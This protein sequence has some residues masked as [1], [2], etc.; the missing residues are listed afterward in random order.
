[1]LVWDAHEVKLWDFVKTP[2]QWS[3]QDTLELRVNE[4][5]AL[6]RRNGKAWWAV[7]LRPT[8]LF[9]GPKP[10]NPADVPTLRAAR[11]AIYHRQV[12]PDLRT[13][14][15]GD[16]WADGEDAVVSLLAG[17]VD[18]KTYGAR[19]AHWAGA[20]AKLPDAARQKVD[21]ALL[22]A[23]HKRPSYFVIL[24]AAKHLN[25]ASPGLDEANRAALRALE[26]AAATKD[27]WGVHYGAKKLLPK[28]A[29]SKAFEDERDT[30][31]VTCRSRKR[32]SKG[33]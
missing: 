24:R 33:K 21:Q 18:A 15:I 22:A 27:S 7:Y 5:V 23:Y 26:R 10:I 19:D 16:A 4:S 6:Y 29:C 3:R 8:G 25:L 13:L 11:P 14:I 28:L 17:T 1:M 30:V 20:R 32:R 31:K 2:E 9:H 12:R